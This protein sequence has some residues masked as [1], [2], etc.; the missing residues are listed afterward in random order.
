MRQLAVTVVFLALTVAAAAPVAWAQPA[1][2]IYLANDDH[3]DYMWSADEAAYRQ[4]FLNMIDFY[5]GQADRTSGNA[6]PY[7]GRFNIDGSFWVWEY[8][9][10]KSAADLARLASRIR[11]GHISVPLNP[12]VLNYGGMP[13]EAVLRSMY[14]AGQ[15]ERRFQVRL[16]IAVAIENQTHPYGL[17][18]LWAGAGAKY[19]WKGVCGCAS[20]IS[21]TTLA[22]RDQEIYW[23]VGA[24]GSRVLMKWN[25]MLAGNASIGGYAEARDPWGIVDFVDTNATFKSKYPFPVVGA[26][27]KGWDDVQTLTDDFITA[28]QAKTTANRQVYVSNELDF[29]RDFEAAHGSQLASLGVSFGNEWDLYVASLSEASADVKRSLARLRAAEAMATLVAL[30]T[31]SF[32]DGR[33]AARDKAMIDFGLYFEHDWTADG[34]ISRDARRNWQRRIANEIGTY[35]NALHADAAAALG[36]LILKSGTDQRFFVF[37]PLGWARTDVA[38]FPYA[39]LA[40]VHVHDLATGAEVPSQLVTVDGSQ[41]LRIL[42]SDVPSVGYRV[43]EIHDGAG[44]AWSLAAAFSGGSVLENAFHRLTFTPRG[45]VTSWLDKARG[46]REL[47]QAR[48][49]YAVNDLGAGTGTIQ[50]E[51]AGPVSVTLLATSAGPLAHT[52]RLTL[53]RDS[54]RIVIENR[55]AQNFGS[56]ESWR[57]SFNAPTPA[58][59]HEEVGAIALAKLASQGGHYS[60]RNARYD[61]LTLNHFA[62][63][64]GNDGVGVTLSNLDLYFMQVGNSTASS[65]DAGT[66]LVKVLAGG[67]VDGTSLGIPNQGGDSS[68]L[69]RFAL[70]SHGDYDPVSAMKFALEH[71]NAFVT[72]A[73]TGGFAYP[74]QTFSFLSISDPGTLLWALKPAEDG[75]SS[76]LVVRMWNLSESPATP[77]VRLAYDTIAAASRLSHVETFEEDATVSAGAL[78]ASLA[79]SQ[80]RTYLVKPSGTGAAPVPV[81]T[82][83]SPASARAGG[84]GFTLTATGSSFV[85][86]SVVQW[87]GSARTTTFVSPT[88]LQ[89]AIPAADISLPGSPAITVATPPPGGGTSSS[90]ILSVTPGA[91]PPPTFTDDPLV[92]RTTVVKAAHIT[93]LRQAIDD[94]RGRN[95]LMAFAWTDQPLVGGITVVRALHVTELRA[96]LAEVYVKIGQAPPGY[97]RANLAGSTIAALDIAELRGAVLAIW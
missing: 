40:P 13:A 4:A 41:R 16:P 15:L 82:S 86:S 85:P 56:T 72:G 5:L 89:A 75:V 18:G 94:L 80:M 68:F 51:S 24:D 44:A 42:A 58:I 32:L 19:S 21:T 71:E 60:D 79:G 31:P 12:L 66:P 46:N 11:D 33:Q 34:P 97:L 36:A 63:V 50:L 55:I 48:N 61:W 26:F 43:F 52:T 57:F 62:D 96:A 88:E 45:A 6:S 25:S 54:P 47:V 30:K 93:E 70:T 20:R 59:R 3:T 91:G 76:G 17:A 77:T 65:L 53:L 38:D 92:V 1:K 39:A 95:G 49:G 64:T 14:Y 69:Q 29:F 9:H 23:M 35:V 83:I 27:G 90:R 78:V 2:R 10:N 37:N 22:N 81:L 74:E 73:V 87:N 28:A 67:Q 7:Q 84:A 8:E